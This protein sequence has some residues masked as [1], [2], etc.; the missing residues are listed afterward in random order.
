MS[1]SLLQLPL[2][3][4]HP[5][6]HGGVGDKES[7]Y[8]FLLRPDQEDI[9]IHWSEFSHVAMPNCKAGWEVAC[10][11]AATC[12]D[13]T[14]TPSLIKEKWGD[15]NWWTACSPCHTSFYFH[16]ENHSACVTPSPTKVLF[17]SINAQK[18]PQKAVLPL[19]PYLAP[20]PW[21]CP[22]TSSGSS[23][24]S[25]VSHPQWSCS[26]KTG[27]WWSCCRRRLGYLPR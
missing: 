20:H 27:R 7:L 26:R 6:W 22:S 5:S 1:T 24:C 19:C 25:P 10:N 2:S 18:N 12:P 15:E 8:S 11:W 14:C 4:L 23:G 13:E 17:F 9:P 21:G 3:H 16:F